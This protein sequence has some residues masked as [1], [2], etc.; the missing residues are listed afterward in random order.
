MVVPLEV[1]QCA[2]GSGSVW[3]PLYYSV[4]PSQKIH[5]R[6]HRDGDVGYAKIGS[7]YDSVYP[8]F[9][10]WRCHFSSLVGMWPHVILLL[11]WGMKE[12]A[13]AVAVVVPYALSL[14]HP[15]VE[16]TADYQSYNWGKTH[17]VAG[18]L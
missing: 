3:F 4:L 17:P 9:P 11:C 2:P 16:Y 12:G 6:N 15:G 1:W 10:H 5:W 13:L 14:Q 18:N 8:S 7:H